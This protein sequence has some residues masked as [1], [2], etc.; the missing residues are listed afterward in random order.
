M[1]CGKESKKEKIADAL[2][3]C[4]HL[5][6]VPA[7]GWRVI[8]LSRSTVPQQHQVLAFACAFSAMSPS[9][10]PSF[11]NFLPLPAQSMLDA[12]SFM[13]TPYF[14]A[15][16]Q[17]SQGM[18]SVLIYLHICTYIYIYIFQTFLES[19][20]LRPEASYSQ[21]YIFVLVLV[22]VFSISSSNRIHNRISISI[23]ISISNSMSMNIN[24]D[25]GIYGLG[26]LSWPGFLGHLLPGM[27]LAASFMETPISLAFAWMS[28]QGMA[29]IFSW[30]LLWFTSSCQN[31]PTII[32]SVPIYI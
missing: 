8:S 6:F 17:S 26:L 29:S 20:T 21:P 13:D 28:S 9:L 12:A 32:H 11:S 5:A 14:L 7:G 18:S 3:S 24:I 4:D 22:L 10:S 15:C 1:S 27:D 23:S 2:E 16:S 19:L 30:A 31:E 25:I